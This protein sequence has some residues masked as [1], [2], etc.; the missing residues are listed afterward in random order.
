MHRSVLCISFRCTAKGLSQTDI[1]IRSQKGHFDTWQKGGKHEFIFP[2]RGHS[3]HRFPGGCERSHFPAPRGRGAG[4]V[5]QDGD[6]R[7]R[8]SSP[9]LASLLPKAERHH[10]QKPSRISP[11]VTLHSSQEAVPLGD[12]KPWTEYHCVPDGI[13][14]TRSPRLLF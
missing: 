7:A 3:K 4:Q 12:F 11:V 6:L 5:R 10:F 2:S 8:R 13:S 9:L 1:R 14:E